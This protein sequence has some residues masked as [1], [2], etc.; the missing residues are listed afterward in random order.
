LIE[1]VAETMAEVMAAKCGLIS[2]EREAI[3]RREGDAGADAR[4]ASGTH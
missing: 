2:A 3:S 1:L 4:V